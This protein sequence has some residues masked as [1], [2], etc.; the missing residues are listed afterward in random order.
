MSDQF[1]DDLFARLHAERSETLTRAASAAQSRERVVAAASVWW[2][3]FCQIIECK[4]QAWNA[5]GATDAHVTCTRNASGSIVLW[6]RCIETE[7][8]LAEARVVMTGRTGDTR[9][10]ESPLIH[11]NEARGSVAAVLSSDSTV[12]SPTEA[13]DHVLMPIFTRAFNG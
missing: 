11:F 13:A 6:H 10:R 4:A 12:K 3:D 9:P 1:V 8:R 2:D 7:L 5:K